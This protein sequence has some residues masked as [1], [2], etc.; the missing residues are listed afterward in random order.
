MPAVRQVTKNFIGIEA[1][2]Q[3]ARRS[4]ACTSAVYVED[5][6]VVLDRGRRRDPADDAEGLHGHEFHQSLIACA[7][8]R[9]FLIVCPC[10]ERIRRWTLLK[11]PFG[12][13]SMRCQ[14]RTK[15]RLRP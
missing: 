6:S 14:R 12:A 9:P 5:S 10:Y 3:D 11:T 8:V 4:A 13:T 7:A 1:V 2:D 15:T